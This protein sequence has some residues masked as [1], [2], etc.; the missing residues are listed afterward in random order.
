MIMLIETFCSICC[1]VVVLG[2][3]GGLGFDFVVLWVI[4]LAP[5]GCDKGIHFHLCCLWWLWR[6]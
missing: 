6:L 4:L 3:N 1:S 2:R 5:V